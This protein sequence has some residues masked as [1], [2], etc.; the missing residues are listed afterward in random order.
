VFFVSWWFNIGFG[1]S[2]TNPEA[3]VSPPQVKGRSCKD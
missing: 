3:G 2:F 1:G